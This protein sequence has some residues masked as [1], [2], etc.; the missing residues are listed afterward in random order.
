M[1]ILGTERIPAI[2]PWIEAAARALPIK[3]GMVGTDLLGVDRSDYGPFRLR[4]IPYLFFSTG[5]NPTYHEMNDVPDTIDFPKLASVSRLV[6]RI[7]RK[8]AQ[9]DSLPKWSGQPDNSLDEAVVLRDVF[10]ILLEHREDLKIR[11]TTL[12]LMRGCLGTLDGVIE[13]GKITP[14]ERLGMLRVAQL[15]LFSVL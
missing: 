9:A 11:P 12:T 6:A 3:V 10:R 14:G 8:A 2:R 15:V 5:E 7:V 4:K 13:R 1:F